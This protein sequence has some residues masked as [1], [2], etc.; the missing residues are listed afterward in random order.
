M[1]YEKSAIENYIFNKT[2]NVGGYPITE[3]LK[4]ETIKYGTLN[5]NEIIGGGHARFE[6]LI[7]PAGLVSFS[8]Q[9]FNVGGGD[10]H[11]NI[12]TDKNIEV[13]DD[14]MFNK[15]FDRIAKIPK[16]SNN[17]TRQ[18]KDQSKGKGV[19]KKHTAKQRT[20]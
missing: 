16:S 13:M 7:V 20:F 8:N 17:K 12:K 14:N 4:K 1:E 5:N 10:C 11:V 3:L 6:N 15:F 18:K 2:T 9:Y 19:D